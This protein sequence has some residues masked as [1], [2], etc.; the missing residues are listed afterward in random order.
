MLINV[1]WIKKQDPSRFV[2]EFF[3]AGGAAGDSVFYLDYSRTA[4]FAGGVWADRD[5]DDLYGYC[6]VVYGQWFWLGTDSEK[7]SDAC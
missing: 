2:L 6:P 7:R 3:R 1:R 5:V 4:P